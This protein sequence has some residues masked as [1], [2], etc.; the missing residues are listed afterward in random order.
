MTKNKRLN[1]REVLEKSFQNPQYF[2]LLVDKYQEAFLRKSMAVVHSREDAEDIVQ[3]TFIKIYK[4]ASKWREQGGATFES[5]IYTILRNTCYSF[6]KKQKRLTTQTVLVDFSEYDFESASKTPLE[7]YESKSLSSSVES[8]LS[9]MPK[10]LSKVLRLYFF[11]ERSQKE[12]A[13][14]E[15]LSLEA[16]RTRIHRAKNYFRKLNTNTI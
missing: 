13:E 5:W 3:E 10:S 14:A 9:K 8:V 2:A 12:I 15:N 1:D 7:D 6:Y 4:N 11:E 16:V